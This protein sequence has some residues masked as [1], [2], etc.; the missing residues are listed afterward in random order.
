MVG[1]CRPQG[2]NQLPMIGSYEDKASATLRLLLED[3]ESEVFAL[4]SAQ[5]GDCKLKEACCRVWLERVCNCRGHITPEQFV[6]FVFRFLK[7]KAE[8]R[9]QFRY[10]RILCLR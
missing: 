10:R 2:N 7:I 3:C 6:D 9:V 1:T 4:F 5:C 8:A